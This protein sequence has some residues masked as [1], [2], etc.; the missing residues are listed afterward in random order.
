MSLARE[1]AR[2]APLIA[3][4]LRR[5]PRRTALT[6][7]GL[8]IAFFLFTSLESLLFTMSNLVSGASR[9]ALLF[10]RAADPDYWRAKLPASYADAIEELPGVVAASPVRVLF[11][12]GRKEGSFAV[13]M[14]VRP[15]AYLKLG[16]PDGVTGDELHALFTERD[17]ALVGARMLED[18]DW[19]VGD[20]VTIGGHLRQRDFTFTIRGDIAR[21]DRLDRVAVVRLDYLEEALGGAGHVTFIQVRARD[22]GLAP[23]VAAAIDR[24]FANY[25]IPTETVTEKAHIAPFIAS[26]SDA[27]D[28]LR[29]V[30]YLALAVTLLVVANSIAVGVRERT[31]EIGALR[32][33]GYGRARVMS[34][35]LAEA[36]LVA[37]IGGTLGA[38]AAYA[39]FSTGRVEVPGAGFVYRS[40]LSVVL[41]A[42]LLSIPL[43]LV[44]GAQ[45]AWGAVRMTISDALRYSE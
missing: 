45:P 20:R 3:R 24:R 29:I 15:D 30:G 41:R 11:G 38:L 18:N 8:V 9:D 12:S 28:G 19:K 14:G 2:Q 25:T 34:L 1:I 44:A 13:A 23:A 43:G 35:V 37:V 10:S 17:A 27:R 36:L 31:R 42:A 6:F 21:G 4:Q 40:D 33:M 7:L 26:L 22:A 32:A 5:S 39:L 16:I